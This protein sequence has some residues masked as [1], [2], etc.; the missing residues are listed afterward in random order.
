M[1]EHND[2]THLWDCDAIQLYGIDW[3][4]EFYEFQKFLKFTKFN[5][6]L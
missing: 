1:N 2:M 6:L 4:F 5:E 3:E